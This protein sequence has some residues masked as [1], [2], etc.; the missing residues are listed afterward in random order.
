MTTVVAQSNDASKGFLMPAVVIDGDTLYVDYLETIYF[1]EPIGTDR[2]AYLDRLRYNI[3][4][5]F[6]YAILASNVLKKMDHDLGT[7]P[8]KR[9]RRK[10][11]NTLDIELNSKFKDELKNLSETQG[12]ILV[13]LVNRQ[14]GRKV[15]DIIKELKGGVNARFYQ[16]AFSF[17]D[18]D[19]KTQYDPFGVD[20]DIEMIV[21]EIEAGNYFK[22]Q[23]INSRIK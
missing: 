18:N 11:I 2:K 6:P 5:V 9:D 14:T 8:S 3:F 16:T 22:H 20:K 21:K 19:L 1:N 4:K 23:P 13:K 7:N 12:K 10:Y 15:Y 17:I